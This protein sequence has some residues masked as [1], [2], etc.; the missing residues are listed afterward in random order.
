MGQPP[1]GYMK[2][3][4]HPKHWNVDDEAAQVVKRIYGMTLDG[5]ETE[6]IAAQLEREEILPPRAYWLKKGVKRP[7]KRQAA[8]VYQVEQLYHHKNSFSARVLRRYQSIGNA[9][10]FTIRNVT[11]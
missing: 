8:A 4:D 5:M 11:W 2:H 1:Y 3:P 10:I 7:G 9:I 6:Q